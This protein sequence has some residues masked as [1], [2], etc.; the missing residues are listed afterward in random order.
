V[1]EAQLKEWKKQLTA[2]K[3]DIKAQEQGFAKRLNAAVDALDEAAAAA[4]LLAILRNDMQ[5]ILE[6]HIGAQRQQVVAAFEN[7]WDKYRVTLTDIE[8][9]RDSAAAELHRFVGALGYA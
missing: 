8:R 1:D 6:R 4:L 3:K 5:V 2:L 9:E 7:W